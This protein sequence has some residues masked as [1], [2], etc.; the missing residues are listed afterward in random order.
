MKKIFTILAALLICIATANA[1]QL[2]RSIQPKPAP[3]KEIDIKDAKT[4]TLKNGLKVFVVEDN[5]APIVYYSLRLDVKPALEGDKAGLQSLFDEVIGNETTKRSKEQL[6]KEIDLIGA[7]INVSSSGGFASGLRKYEDK[8]LELLTDMLF[9]SKFT[10]EEL[11]LHRDKSKSAL[12]MVADDPSSIGDR[13]SNVLLYGKGFPNGEVETIET[14]ENVELL[15]LQ[16]FYDTYFA[17]NVTRLVI[18]GNITEKEARANAEKYF[19]SWK[20]KDVPVATYILPQAPASAKVAMVNKDEAP[21]S[22]INITYPIEYRTGA[23]DA[24]A[25]SVLNYIFG[26]GMSSRLFQNLRETHSYT[27]G[28]YSSI[29]SHELVGS[30][31]LTS[32]RG[33]A[34]VKGAATDSAIYQIVYEMNGMINGLVSEKELKDAKAS[35]AGSFGRSISEPSVIANFAVNI[36]KYNL[37]KDYY[38]N[39]LKRLE[40]VTASDVQAAAK[41]YLKPNNA[42]YIVVGDKS[43]ADNLKQFATNGTVQFYDMD[44]NLVEAPVAKSAGVSA[45]QVI[46][47]YVNAI[48]GK[49]AIAKIDSYKASGEMSMM[50]QKL[51][52]TQAFRKPNSTAMIISMGGTPMQKIVF[53][54]S[55]VKISGMQGEQE[56]TEGDVFDGMKAAA[57]VCPEM[58]YLAKGYQL[59]VKGIE[60]VNG[61]DAYAME[62]TK[63][64]K[65]D[66]EYYDVE[67]GLKVKSVTTTEGPQGQIQQVKEYG[68]YKEVN[69]V[70]FP[71]AMKQ[72]AA[73]MTI[74]TTLSSIE[75]NQLVDDSLFQ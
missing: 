74:S 56:Y 28:V 50:G 68:D 35:I 53:D 15:D 64:G 10:Q 6:S 67:S 26:G 66:I 46:D 3:A 25:I 52:V 17:P 27:Y 63:D 51:E 32:G 44:G 60:Q 24:S 29:N 47:S 40:A 59:T 55:K 49:D 57:A 16:K 75:V 33:S 36:D 19:G 54:G 34:S 45:E 37:P 13:V 65:T 21:Q 62:V 18:V 58:S 4:F 11:D 22:I 69:G 39:Y 73:G 70:K 7:R 30:F 31:G 43:H 23:A 5:R 2:D 38:K 8:M 48:G 41:K 72:L 9:N 42:W 1:Q 14:L 12:S 71:H 20:K 61:K